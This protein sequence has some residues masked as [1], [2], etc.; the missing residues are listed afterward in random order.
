MIQASRREASCSRRLTVSSRRLISR[1]RSAILSSRSRISSNRTLLSFHHPGG[2]SSLSWTTSLITVCTGG[3]SNVACAT[4]GGQDVGIA[5]IGPGP[6]TPPG[7][8]AK[9]SASRRA[10]SASRVATLL[11]RAMRAWDRLGVS[12]LHTPGV[13]GSPGVAPLDEL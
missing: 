12:T 10:T 8:P 9:I 2:V 6:T 3:G 4:Q 7:A 13:E 5:P 1:S 11:S